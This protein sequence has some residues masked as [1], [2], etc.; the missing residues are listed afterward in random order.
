M[1]S[2][3]QSI[4]SAST[5]ITCGTYTSVGTSAVAPFAKA[6]CRRICLIAPQTFTPGGAAN[7]SAV[8]FGDAN[9]QNDYISSD[10]MRDGAVLIDD[11]SKLYLKFI[12]SGDKI[13][14]RIES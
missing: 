9:T 8:L 13:E 3:E 11:P 6:Q 7:T 4:D 2:S 1:P 5:S 14:Y 12:T 10:G